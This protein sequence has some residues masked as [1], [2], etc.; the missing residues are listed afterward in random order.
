M[1][2]TEGL[3]NNNNP[4]YFNSELRQNSILNAEQ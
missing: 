1:D 4:K 2:A 3:Q